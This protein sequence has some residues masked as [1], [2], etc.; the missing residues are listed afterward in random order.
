M[1]AIF[2]HTYKA[3]KMEKFKGLLQGAQSWKMI[4]FINYGVSFPDVTES[5]ISQPFSMTLADTLN[6][7]VE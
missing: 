4:S 6:F 2:K 5:C 7:F 1:L 3:K